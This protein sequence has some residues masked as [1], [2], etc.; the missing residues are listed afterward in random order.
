MRSG[1]NMFLLRVR[2][3][4]KRD[5]DQAWKPASEGG[6]GVDALLTP[7]TLATAPTY[8]E[9]SSLD[10][11]TQTTVQDYCTQPVNL[12]GLPAATLP[13]RLSAESHLPIS[14]Q[15]IGPRSRDSLVLAICKWLQNRLDFPILR[16]K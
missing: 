4:V 15:V 8:E 11:R 9:F 13:V 2:R 10:N 6:Y 7:V 3:L 1:N 5:F 16:I 12:A 14:L